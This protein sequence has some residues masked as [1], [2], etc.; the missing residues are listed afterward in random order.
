MC[1]NINFKLRGKEKTL[2]KYKKKRERGEEK[3]F[4]KTDV[5]LFIKKKEEG[6]KSFIANIS[7]VLYMLFTQYIYLV[8]TYLNKQKKNINNILIKQNLK[9]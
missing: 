9:L 2:K 4:N 8:Y 5:I 6:K 1:I 7:F 3:S